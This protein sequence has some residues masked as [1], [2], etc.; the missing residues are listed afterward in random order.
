MKV[1]FPH[2]GNAYIPFRTLLLELG[3][4]PV[5]PPPITPRTVSLGTKL[6]PEFACYPL[7][8]NLGNYLEAIEA[9]AEMIF[10]AGGVGPCRF[11]YYGEVQREILREA[12]FNLEF[13]VLEAPKTH[14]GE[15]WEKIRH[16]FP[17]HRPADL[18]RAARLAW[19]KADALD[20]FDR[21]SV[22]IRP[23]E[24]VPGSVSK[25]QHLFYERLDQ[26]ELSRDIQRIGA[27][28][29]AELETCACPQRQSERVKVLLVGEIYMVLE[30]RVNFRI[31]AT[32]GEMGLEV[33]RTIYFTEWIR[34]QL[35]FSIINPGWRK[36]LL[37]LAEPYLSGFVG[38]HGL[39][40]VAHTVEAGVNR[41]D[42]AVQ[43]LPFTCMPE[44]VAMQALPAVRHDFQIP[45]LSII[46]DE[47][48]AEAGILTRLEAFSDLL[49][50]NK[51][52]SAGGT[53]CEAVFRG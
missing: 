14:P 23:L 42:G 29:L 32:L 1:T 16:Y 25:L 26:A 44:I 22:K 39:E 43:I 8:I 6:A 47:H 36:P 40:T 21:L 38:G 31:E 53:H 50:R 12:G 35:L 9:G 10:M 33:R 45:V 46:I 13:L 18:I 51:L 17:R 19:L 30:T 41:Y 5:V 11:G 3:L 2:L 7:K 15:L 20:R 34:D 49:H 37:K 52:L 28:G 27:E 24:R 48:S 4:E